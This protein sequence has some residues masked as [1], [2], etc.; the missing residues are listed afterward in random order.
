MIKRLLLAALFSIA[1][2][3]AFAACSSP[4]VVKDGAGS[5]V[6]M[7]AATG[8]DGNCQSKIDIDTSSQLHNDLTAAI[9]AGTNLIGKVGI[10]QTTPGATNGVQV[11]AALPAGTNTI[12]SVKQTDGTTVVVTDPCQGST[13]LYKPISITTATTTNVITGASAKKTYICHIFLTSAAADN[14]AIIEGTTGG[15]C[16]SGT[17][18]L[19]GGTTAANGPNFAANGGV[20]LGNGGF[21]IA[22]TATNQN[23]VCLITSAA[24]P[25]AGVITY[26][27]Q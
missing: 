6:S 2:V 21:S 13:K 16:G 5:N 22:A 24:T 23:D 18:G 8:A 10:D 26:A 19:I 17:A 1:A 25:L 3:P 7:S 11:N 20:S 15:T 9:P 27:Q 14:V 4:V 12:G